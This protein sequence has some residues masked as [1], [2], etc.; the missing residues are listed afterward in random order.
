[1]HGRLDQA[2][3][4]S[5]NS[6]KSLPRR[7]LYTIAGRLI[8]QH[9]MHPYLHHSVIVLQSPFQLGSGVVSASTISAVPAA[10]SPH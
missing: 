4:P 7:R 6:K 8:N 1:M 9:H 3:P 10:D 5:D 2:D